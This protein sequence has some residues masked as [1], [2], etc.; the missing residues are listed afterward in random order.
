MKKV[1]DELNDT[2]ALQA[3]LA[4]HMKYKYQPWWPKAASKTLSHIQSTAKYI[5][6]QLPSTLLK[7]EKLLDFP[8][9][10]PTVRNS[11]AK[12]GNFKCY[13]VVRRGYS[14]HSTSFFREQF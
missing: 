10:N 3:S 14:K 6:L 11:V 4:N 1:S 8:D 12:I 5:F 9:C 2:F 13:I 7:I